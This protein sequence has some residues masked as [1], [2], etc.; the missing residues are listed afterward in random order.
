MSLDPSV[1][2]TIDL[3]KHNGISLLHTLYISLYLLISFRIAVTLKVS[4]KNEVYV[5]K[6]ES[7]ILMYQVIFGT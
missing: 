2:E 3:K 7:I 5:Y 6:D 1:H 4:N